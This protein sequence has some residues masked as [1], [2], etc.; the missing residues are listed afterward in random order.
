MACDER[1]QC[2]VNGVWEVFPFLVTAIIFGYVLANIFIGSKYSVLF[3]S[4]LTIVVVF[5]WCLAIR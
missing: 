4:I 2:L 5:L 3:I 1:E